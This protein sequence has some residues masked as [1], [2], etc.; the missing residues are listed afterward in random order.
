MTEAF[1][2]SNRNGL[3]DRVLVDTLMACGVR[4]VVLCPGGRNSLLALTLHRT[5]G[6]H[7]ILHVDERSGAFLALGQILADGAPTAVCTTSGSAVANLL[8][9]LTE[10]NAR[11]LPLVLLTCDRPF[12]GRGR[13]EPQTL[14][15]TEL[16]LQFV[17]ARVA[18]PDPF[19]GTPGLAEL[20]ETLAAAL[21]TAI[22][23]E[24][25]GPLHINVPQWGAYCATE[26]DP[27][28]L[29][30]LPPLPL[31][32]AV[33]SAPPAPRSGVDDMEAAVAAVQ[34][35]AGLRGLIVAGPDQPL[36]P[37]A[38]GELGRRIGYPLIADVC[39]GLRHQ[40]DPNLVTT[41]DALA[42]SPV[43][44]ITQ[45]ELVIRLGDTPVSPA[46]QR[47]LRQVCCPVL[48]IT[49]HEPQAD[50]L[51][52]H[53]IGLYPP[54]AAALDTLGRA[55]APGDGAWSALWRGADAMAQSG[56]ARFL[57]E[58]PWGEAVAAARVCAAPG[59]DAL[60]LANSL[61]VRYGGLLVPAAAAP[62]RVFTAR[63]VNGT[64]GTLGLILGEILATGDRLLALIGDQAFTHDLPGL[65]NPLWATA[66][67]ALCVMN[68]GGG[69]LFDMVPCARIP[70]YEATMRN[71]PAV[72]FSGIARAFGFLH[73][74][75][76]DVAVLDAA[77]AEAALAD[78]MLLIEIRVPP[79]TAVRDIPGLVRA[80]IL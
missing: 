64:D 41:A 60:H 63:G 31:P 78:T 46:L 62:A 14:P 21:T 79:G 25:P 2:H 73:R 12:S 35:R 24:P 36:S 48:S 15:Q 34:G 47:A 6:M 50:F 1:L 54:D 68:N 23:G 53:A 58:A 16:C 9:A 37:A 39:S 44:G 38:V 67:G 13:R 7:C 59:F 10:A 75:C 20:G 80:M 27:P 45:A 57:A 51:N 30:P 8:P 18:L 43:L 4:R 40:D 49:R 33:P 32:V 5:P 55:L 19:A 11:N 29:P 17:R 76:E 28:G 70:G 3:W 22:H 52:H 74:P 26:D 69:A 65:A 42:L 56:R 66:R 72:D 61:S 77:L 71:A